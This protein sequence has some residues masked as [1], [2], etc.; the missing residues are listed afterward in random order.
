MIEA[1]RI[2]QKE[3]EGNPN[4]SLLI[5]MVKLVIE[6]KDDRLLKVRANKIVGL[7]LSF[8]GLWREAEKLLRW[9]E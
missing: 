2:K 8:Y 6:T 9:N 7:Y 5:E 3:A 1:I 4:T